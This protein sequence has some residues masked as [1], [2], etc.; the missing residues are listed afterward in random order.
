M[1]ASCL[2]SVAPPSSWITPSPPLAAACATAAL[3]IVSCPPTISKIEV[4]GGSGG[5]PVPPPRCQG[6]VPLQV[7]STSLSTQPP[8][9]TVSGPATPNVPSP[10][11]LT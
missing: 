11:T 10:V 3:A 1:L 5:V 9:V 7:V 2:K 4:G 8:S 6:A